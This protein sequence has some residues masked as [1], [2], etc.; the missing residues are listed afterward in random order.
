MQQ[1]AV[2]HLPRDRGQVNS[3]STSSGWLSLSRPLVAVGAVAVVAW[4]ATVFHRPVIVERVRR[5]HA[6]DF[7]AIQAVVCA[8]M[9][10]TAI[11]LLGRKKN[12][13]EIPRKLR[14]RGGRIKSYQ[15]KFVI[16]Q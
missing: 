9:D 5:R 4:P 8:A 12:I 16:A 6:I 2:D 1:T 13:H 10:E 11:M 15:S 7:V 14:D 3:P